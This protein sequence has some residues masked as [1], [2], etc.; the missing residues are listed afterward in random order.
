METNAYFYVLY[1][2]DDTLYAGYTTDL[3]RRFH[4]HNQG[5]GAKYTRLPSRRPVKMVYA[6]IFDS[7]SQAMKAEYAFKQLSRQQKES[8]L[9]HNQV[10]IPLDRRRKMILNDKRMD[11]ND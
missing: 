4:Q 1:C 5:V 8:Y 6:E 11:T 10:H 2:R 7:K 3:N 9:K